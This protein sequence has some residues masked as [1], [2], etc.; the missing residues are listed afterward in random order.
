MCLLC[1][2]GSVSVEVALKQAIQYWDSKEQR[3]EKVLEY[4][5]GYHGDTFGAMFVSDPQNSMHSIYTSYGQI[6][7]LLKLHK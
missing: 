3:K 4:Q 7:Y 6:I 2:S 5:E 1:D